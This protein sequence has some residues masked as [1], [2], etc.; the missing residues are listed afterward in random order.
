MEPYVLRS[1]SG[2]SIAVNCKR[3][4]SD[5]T[6]DSSHRVVISHVKKDGNSTRI[7]TDGKLEN[8]TLSEKYEIINGTVEDTA[9][10]ILTIKGKA[11]IM[12]SYGLKGKYFCLS[13]IIILCNISFKLM[14]LQRNT[15]FHIGND[16]RQKVSRSPV[17]IG[18]V[19][20]WGGGWGWR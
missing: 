8:A 9:Q 4:T 19:C 2:K 10:Y 16:K 20:V 3:N 13:G 7:A 6:F 15:Q 18:T 5:P 17:I 1:E 12:L 11:E 14:F